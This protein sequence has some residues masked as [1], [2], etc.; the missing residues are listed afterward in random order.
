[1]KKKHLRR[2]LKVMQKLVAGL[3]DSLIE[4]TTE[5]QTVRAE[6]DEWKV[7]AKHAEESA[8]DLAR[9]SQRER[10]SA[11]VVASSGGGCAGHAA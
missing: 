3:E 8:T 5:L 6:R 2:A 1:M 7:R 11:P 9:A 4:R 10:A